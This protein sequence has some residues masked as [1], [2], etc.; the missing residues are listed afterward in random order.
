MPVN[1]GSA[2]YNGFMGSSQPKVNPAPGLNNYSNLS[3]EG[4]DPMA[5]SINGLGAYDYSN[6]PTSSNQLGFQ[7][8]STAN[9]SNVGSQVNT[10]DIA[11]LQNRAFDGG[12]TYDPTGN[13][14]I[15]TA[16]AQLRDT[17]SGQDQAT[18]ALQFGANEAQA[19]RE[20]AMRGAQQQQFAQGGLSG[21]QQNVLAQQQERAFA[22]E[23]QATQAQLGQQVLGRA[24]QAT[25]Q[26][27]SLGIQQEQFAQQAAQMQDARDRWENEFGLQAEMSEQQ[28]NQWASEFGM[29]V[30]QAKD[31]QDQWK[32]QLFTQQTGMQQTT[33]QFY[34][35]LN[36]DKDRMEI[37]NKQWVSEFGLTKAMSQADLE[38][39]AAEYDLSVEQVRQMEQQW[40]TEQDL[41][42]DQ[43]D[44]SV[45]QWKSALRFQKGQHLDSL[46]QL[47]IENDFTE[48]QLSEMIRSNVASEGLQER[49][50]TESERSALIAEGFT[51]RQLDELERGN[52]VGEDL[53]ERQF[54]E[55]QKQ[56]LFDN[57]LRYDEY[58]V[59]KDL[60][61]T[62]IEQVNN[63]INKERYESALATTDFTNQDEVAALQ[64]S[65]S[66][67]HGA[68]AEVPSYAQFVNESWDIKEGAA[69]KDLMAH[70]TNM[71]YQSQDITFSEAIENDPALRSKMVDMVKAQLG[72]S[73]PSNRGQFLSM[74]SK[75]FDQMQKSPT[76][77]DREQAFNDFQSS[78]YYKNYDGDTAELDDFFYELDFLQ[79]TGG[80]KPKGMPDGSIG[81]VDARGNIITTHT[82]YKDIGETT[83]GNTYT[84]DDDGISSF[85]LNGGQLVQTKIADGMLKFK[86]D[87]GSWE[88]INHG[89]T[90]NSLQGP[91]LEQ[92]QAVYS[93]DSTGGTAW[94]LNPKPKTDEVKQTIPDSYEKGTTSK[95]YN[96]QLIV[97]DKAYDIGDQFFFDGVL[98]EV[99]KID[100][101]I[102]VRTAE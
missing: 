83:N 62:Q 1:F 23:R 95:V 76:D 50:L 77:L 44:D 66:N 3:S 28:L 73:V 13:Q 60:A 29:S 59:Q 89:G 80:A 71:G 98:K 67:Y 39:W 35:S 97:G 56:N 15:A 84:T 57:E 43:F 40:N 101:K 34:E 2:G 7:N 99:K 70:V 26:L 64:Q 25:A 87:D 38:K 31:M 37:A 11:N 58:L 8:Q 19:A 94:W 55:L 100:G 90:Q 12:L 52:L 69:G 45:D 41:R 53:S 88:N 47:A 72:G 54:K 6:I 48:Q 65:Y 5:S 18:Q 79:Q 75:I 78:D 27:A 85:K 4:V 82:D 92:A 9:F 22:G 51:E 81:I 46:A 96:D 93:T 30:E 86:V 42:R 33:D 36:L 16:E 20:A 102:T 21:A 74:G 10:G 14:N 24:D 68:D 17:L 63:A 32:S 49:Q 91:I 61:N